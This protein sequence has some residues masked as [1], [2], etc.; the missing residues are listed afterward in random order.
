MQLFPILSEAGNDSEILTLSLAL[1]ALFGVLV[2]EG[3]GF[4][5]RMRDS[6]VPGN[7]ELARRI[8][9][10]E[11]RESATAAAVS[12]ARE[13]LAGIETLIKQWQ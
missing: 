4:V 11:D 12:D 8:E 10:L 5:G 7:A 6:S 2:R 3:F 1:V 9:S 13:T